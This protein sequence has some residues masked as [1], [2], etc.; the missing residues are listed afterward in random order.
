MTPGSAS[1]QGMLEPT[2]LSAPQPLTAAQV[3]RGRIL[4]I[5]HEA[6]IA[7][8]LQRI[9]RQAGWRVVGRPTSE[10]HARSLIQRSNIDCAI[11]DF[12]AAS[13][14]G[15]TA[16]DLLAEA[17][18]PFL[19]LTTSRRNLPSV[20]AAGWAV[21]KPYTAQELLCALDEALGRQTA[22]ANPPAPPVD[23]S[24]RVMPQL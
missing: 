5:E 10:A 2:T 24:P 19:V 13:D 21:E 6:V 23:S 15:R 7:L 17:H 16:A 9:L 12:D 11:I 18:I 22:V 1:L 4:I 8:D 20:Y 14:L 3:P